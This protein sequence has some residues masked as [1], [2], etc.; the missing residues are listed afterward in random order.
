MTVRPL[1]RIIIK[2]KKS[3]ARQFSVCSAVINVSG[4]EGRNKITIKI[5]YQFKIEQINLSK[6]EM[7]NE[8]MK[9]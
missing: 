4:G 5:T 9:I 3:F 8:D 1:H 6:L 2:K 7:N